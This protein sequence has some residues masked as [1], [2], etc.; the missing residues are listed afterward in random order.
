MIANDK[1]QQDQQI[2]V[3]IAVQR[4]VNECR[5]MTK[6]VGYGDGVSLRNISAILSP[7]SRNLKQATPLYVG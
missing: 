1:E 3:E 6:N 5:K 2:V 4:R 7:C